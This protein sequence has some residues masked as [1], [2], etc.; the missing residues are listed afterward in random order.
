MPAEDG[1]GDEVTGAAVDMSGRLV[2][3]ATRVGSETLLAQMSELVKQALATKA[4]AQRLADTVAA[5]FVPCVINLA[6]VTL[7][8]WL[9]VGLPA[10]VAWS[11][12][13]AVLVVACPCALGLRYTHCPDDRAGPRPS[14]ASWSRARRRWNAQA[15]FARS[16]W[17]SPAPY[18]RPS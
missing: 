9:G 8:F 18:R 5:V 7:G 16:S 2:V 14:W 12:A 1:P 13:V 15:G 4:G 6:V 11:T 3:R 10:A 17:T